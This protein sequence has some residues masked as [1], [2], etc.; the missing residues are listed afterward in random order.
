[1]VD[2]SVI[3]SAIYP[4]KWMGMHESLMNKNTTSFELIFVG[5]N[6]PDYELPE[7]VRFIQTEV[8]PVQCKEIACRAAEGEYIID[9][10]DD[11][12][13]VPGFLNAFIDHTHGIDMDK[14]IIIGHLG[15]K[16][17]A[18]VLSKHY[19]GRADLPIVG[20]MFLMKKNVWQGLGGLERRLKA[21]YY[22]DDLALRFYQSGGAYILGNVKKCL[23]NEQG[24]GSLSRASAEHDF[25]VIEKLWSKDGVFTPK[26]QD[27]LYPFSDE[28]LL[29]INQMDRRENGQKTQN[30]NQKHQ[31][32]SKDD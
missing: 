21:I 24:T 5:P 27:V 30:K 29:I 18:K 16:W 4:E 2:V 8:N 23:A 11:F 13:F 17:K 14:H 3:L 32:P 26:R 1:M 7:N 19:L 28:D 31:G 25:P 22:N 9:V 15:R 12:L 10:A 20:L 6:A